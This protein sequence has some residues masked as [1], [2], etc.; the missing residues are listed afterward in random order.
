MEKDKN[1]LL[2]CFEISYVQRLQMLILWEGKDRTRT[3][4][5]FSDFIQLFL[6]L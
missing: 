1:C 4:K 6:L 5:T 3:I 2:G